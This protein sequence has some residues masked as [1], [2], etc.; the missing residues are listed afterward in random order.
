MGRKGVLGWGRGPT[1]LTRTQGRERT[2][3]KGARFWGSWGLG[4]EGC[5]G[6]GTRGS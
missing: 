6:V 5:C 3:E 2:K 4:T 1:E